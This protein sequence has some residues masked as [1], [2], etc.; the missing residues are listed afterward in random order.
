MQSCK[1]TYVFSYFL[2]LSHHSACYIYL[3]TYVYPNHFVSMTKGYFKLL[4]SQICFH[5]GFLCGFQWA[6]SHHNWWF[7]SW[8]WM[9]TKIGKRF[10]AQLCQIYY[11]VDLIFPNKYKVFCGFQWDLITTYYFTRYLE[12]FSSAFI[13]KRN[14]LCEFI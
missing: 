9:F 2:S 1:I 12:K 7:W 4:N 6:Q 13:M 3:C 8:G 11:E 5:L 14:Y 10:N